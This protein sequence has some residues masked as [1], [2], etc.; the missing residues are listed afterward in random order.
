MY[1]DDTMIQ[2][3]FK[4]TKAQYLSWNKFFNKFLQISG[5]KPNKSNCEV[6][7]IGILKGMKCGMKCVN[8]KE[9]PVKILGIHYSYNKILE[10]EENFRKHHK[11]QLC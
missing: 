6:A 3:S 4:K 8:L 5:L 1:G 7:G 9:S 11:N 2:L 10:N